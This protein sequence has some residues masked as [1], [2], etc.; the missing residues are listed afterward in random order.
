[1][2]KEPQPH[3]AL[4]QNQLNLI[5]LEFIITNNLAFNII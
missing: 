4:K 5:L 1:M 2:F 3:A